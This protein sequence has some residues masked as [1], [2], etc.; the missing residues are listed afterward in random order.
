MS[1]ATSIFSAENLDAIRRHLESVGFVSVLHWHLHGARHP[2]PLAFSDFEAFE[3]YM[4]D[5]AK[6][7]D[8]IDVWPFP[9]DNGERIAKGK[10]PE[11]DGSI[12]QGGAY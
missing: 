8:A 4:K 2:T 12:L 3:G 1:E 7:G 5:Y 6:A 11:H 10:M 9:T